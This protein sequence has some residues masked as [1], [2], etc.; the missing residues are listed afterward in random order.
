M[1]LQE[2]ELSDV[3]SECMDNCFEAV[4]ACEWC[5]E[6]CREMQQAS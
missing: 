4:Q 6:S 2:L 3:E 5:A 1:A